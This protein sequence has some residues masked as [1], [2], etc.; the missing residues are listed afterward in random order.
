MK[1]A[2]EE[3]VAR[4]LYYCMVSGS[5]CG[6]LR[7]NPFKLKERS[8]TLHSLGLTRRPRFSASLVPHH[9]VLVCVCGVGWGG[10]GWMC[11]SSVVWCACVC[12]CV[13]A[14]ERERERE[15]EKERQRQIDH[16]VKII[17]CF[18]VQRYSDRISVKKEAPENLQC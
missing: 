12:V 9:F 6:S 7:W 16:K 18:R 2:Q 15:R 14:R 4:Q 17:Y 10:V 13:R 5:H 8:R 11:T 1:A 3:D